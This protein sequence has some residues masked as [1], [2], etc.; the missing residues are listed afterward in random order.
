MQHTLAVVLCFA[1]ARSVTVPAHALAQHARVLVFGVVNLMNDDLLLLKNCFSLQEFGN[2]ISVEVLSVECSIPTVR[3]MLICCRW[4][5]APFSLR[6][7][8]VGGF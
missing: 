8:A 5:L 6:L 7:A 4:P 2:K 3:S 1:G